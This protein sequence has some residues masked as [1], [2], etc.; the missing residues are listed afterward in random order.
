MPFKIK[1]THSAEPD[2][3]KELRYEQDSIIIGRGPEC[4]LCLPDAQKRMV[5]RHHAKISRNGESYSLVDLRSRNRTYLNDQQLA[6]EQPHP[7]KAGDKIKI[8]DFLLE[9]ELVLPAPDEL[10]QTIVR[11]NPFLNEAGELAGVLQRMH[12]K[13]VAVQEPGRISDLQ[14]AMYDACR[15]ARLNETAE[16]IHSV[17][18]ALHPSSTSD[19][20]PQSVNGELVAQLA[21]AQAEIAALREEN[22]RLKSGG[23]TTDRNGTLHLRISQVL[24]ILLAAMAG[25]IK[26]PATFKLEW[27]G[28]TIVEF[29][30]FPSIYSGS[31]EEIRKHLFDMGISEGLATRRLAILKQAADEAV[32]HQVALQDGYNQAVEDGARDLLARIDPKAIRQKLLETKYNSRFKAILVRALP[33]LLDW[34]V[35]KFYT[36]KH[37]ELSGEVRGILEQTVFRSHFARGYQRRKDSARPGAI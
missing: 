31:A 1:V 6:P 12:E 2:A 5:S 23:A 8:G 32:V 27:M 15:E 30:D 21:E 18:E 28:Y 7:L 22:R 35:H 16:V 26:A 20:K 4:G 13:F 33:F 25:L 9:F 37:G 14:E 11:F 3:P 19:H 29:K 34:E 17:L 24:E 36:R 10:Q